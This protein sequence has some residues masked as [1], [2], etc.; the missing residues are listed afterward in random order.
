[1]ARR[2]AWAIASLGGAGAMVLGAVFPGAVASGA[3]PEGRARQ[4]VDPDASPAD[5]V[6]TGAFQ[7]CSAYYG[8]G[9]SWAHVDVT[10]DG[11]IDESLQYPDGYQLV[12]TG[13]LDGVPGDESCTPEVLTQETWDLDFLGNP[14][15]YGSVTALP[16]GSNIVIP[17][18]GLV[19]QVTGAQ[20][21]LTFSGEFPGRTITVDSATLP[22][23]Q[24]GE[25][26]DEQYVAY[27]VATLG[28]P[29][30]TT[31]QEPCNANPPAPDAV[32]AANAAY[33]AMTSDFQDDYQTFNVG[34]PFTDCFRIQSLQQYV[35][36]YWFP[37]VWGTD[38][39]VTFALETPAPTPAASPL[40]I[41]PTFT[42]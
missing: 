28:E 30:A 18:Q 13:E 25:T 19:N 41:E 6:S 36:G 24:D 1:M 31:F 29:T 9:K 21:Q 27:L 23:F 39:P 7:S 15:P 20:L 10:S 16:P 40:V 33:A 34:P 37:Y 4:P 12:L 38:N 5:D 8:W 32:A 2:K 42:G 11:T 14:H 22:N 3:G 35:R 26:Y 17:G